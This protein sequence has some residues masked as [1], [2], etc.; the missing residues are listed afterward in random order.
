[1]RTTVSYLLYGIGILGFLFALARTYYRVWELRKEREAPGRKSRPR[2][3]GQE[4]EDK[5]TKI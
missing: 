3:D 1:M 4:S 5:P 2:A